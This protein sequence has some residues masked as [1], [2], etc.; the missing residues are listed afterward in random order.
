MN[1]VTSCFCSY[2]ILLIVS[3]S[4]V[5]VITNH[6]WYSSL[7]T[8]L[9]SW[10]IPSVVYP[11]FSPL[12]LISFINDRK[13]IDGMYYPCFASERLSCLISRHIRQTS[14]YISEFFQDYPRWFYEYIY[15][16][17]SFDYLLIMKEKCVLYKFIYV[18]RTSQ[19]IYNTRL[20]YLYLF[21]ILFSF[22]DNCDKSVLFLF[23]FLNLHKK[24]I[25][26]VFLIRQVL[27]HYDRDN[28]ILDL[29]LLG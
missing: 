17:I 12:I 27:G 24:Y 13:I 19:H 16:I 25:L 22:R 28:L 7:K 18:R 14:H 1:Y 10:K 5:W 11:Y 15:V 3:M 2:Y 29:N 9:E 26:Y 21:Q 8:L 20:F 4:W 23:T 6:N